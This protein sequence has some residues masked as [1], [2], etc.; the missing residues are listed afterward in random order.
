MTINPTFEL[1]SNH[2]YINLFGYELW[3]SW[4]DKTFA[5]NKPK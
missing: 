3:W 5:A 1:S 4:K 2:L